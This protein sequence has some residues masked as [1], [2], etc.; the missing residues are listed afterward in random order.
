MERTLRIATRGSR[1]ALIQSYIIGEILSNNGIKYK[2]IPVKSEGDKDL[3]KPL[4]EYNER[5]IFVK[6]INEEILKGNADIAVHSAKDLPFDI[7]EELEIS[8]YSERGDTRDYF[9]SNIAMEVFSGTVGGSSIRRQNFLSI[10]YDKMS[11]KN[12]RGNID[13]RI[14]KWKNNEV[15]GLVIAKVAIDRLGLSLPGEIISESVLPPAPNQGLIAVVTRK[16]SE[17]SKFFNSIRNLVSFWEGDIERKLMGKLSI[18]C[19]LAVSI[20]AYQEIR[21]I[22][23]S[24]AREGKRYDLSF[25][26]F[27]DSKAI[28]EMRDIIYG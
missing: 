26:N 15:D 4:Y 20:R 14:T 16:N 17:E 19:D 18:G 8:Y 11:F 27:P 1:L 7:G 23:F 9:V 3:T 5:G 12:L 2:I 10:K 6:A 13:T 22:K 25:K 24:F 21:T 28:R